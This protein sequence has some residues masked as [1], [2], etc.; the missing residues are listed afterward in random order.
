M[1]RSNGSR[2]RREF[3]SSQIGK[4]KGSSGVNMLL[5]G[6]RSMYL[7]RAEMGMFRTKN[8]EE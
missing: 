2:V 7:V 3:S 5:V 8:L 4:Q 1:E 6:I